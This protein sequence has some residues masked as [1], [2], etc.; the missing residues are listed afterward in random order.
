MATR[1]ENRDLDHLMRVLEAVLKDTGGSM[2][3]MKEKVLPAR[4]FLRAHL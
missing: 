3:D 2:D 1:G 4:H